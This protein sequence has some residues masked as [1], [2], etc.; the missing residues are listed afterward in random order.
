LLQP[1]L[2]HYF[3]RLLAQKGLLQRHYT[4]NIDTLERVAGVPPHRLVEAHGSFN[5]AHCI[6]CKREYSPAY[7]KG[8][9]RGE[10]QSC[11]PKR[12]SSK[13]C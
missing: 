13:L 5:T 12:V 2:S 4:Q 1:T 7:I 11:F 9:G 10:P 8:T 6:G 3:S